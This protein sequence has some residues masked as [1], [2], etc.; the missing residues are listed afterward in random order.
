MIFI[1]LLVT[2]ILIVVGGYYLYNPGWLSGSDDEPVEDDIINREIRGPSG[3]S[4][5]G[6]EI[7]WVDYETGLDSAAVANKPIFIDFYTDW[8]T[9]CIYMEEDTYSQST[10]IQ[11]SKS[12]VPVK[13]DGDVRKD[14]ITSYNINGY[15]TTVFLNSQG[16]EISRRVGYIGPTEFLE[17][18]DNAL[19]NS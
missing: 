11:K 18:M 17:E 16:E 14:L 4:T 12:F 1:T 6:E 7:S 9:Y 19:S 13:V 15:P 2:F 3:E 10:V 8:C 5:D